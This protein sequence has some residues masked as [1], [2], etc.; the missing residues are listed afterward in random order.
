MNSNTLVQLLQQSFR[1][2]V[3]A[4]TSI[5]ETLQDPKKRS[6][7]LSEL[8]TQLTQK[9]QEWSQ[10]GEMTEQ[11]ARRLLEQWLTQQQRRGSSA[12]T[13]EGA[14]PPDSSNNGD[15]QGEIEQLT[16]Q[17]IALRKELENLRQAKS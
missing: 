1:I 17:V 3:G 9:A 14:Y 8:Q 16:E 15:I 13:N 5:L 12:Y 11:E 4:T 2:G 10:K 6:E 7:T